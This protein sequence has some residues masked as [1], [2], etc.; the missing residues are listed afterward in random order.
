MC[1]GPS[2]RSCFT[3]DLPAQTVLHGKARA[4][5]RQNGI[6]RKPKSAAYGIFALLKICTTY[7]NQICAVKHA[8]VDGTQTVLA[9][10]CVRLHGKHVDVT[11]LNSKLH[12]RFALAYLHRVD[13]ADFRIIC[14]NYTVQARRCRVTSA[15][16]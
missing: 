16:E 2:T 7:T 8:R 4:C 3:V 14:A 15:Y 5:R 13:D 11:S 6:L 10:Y 9:V 1:I 12:W